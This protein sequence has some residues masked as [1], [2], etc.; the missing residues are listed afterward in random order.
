LQQSLRDSLKLL[1]KLENNENTHLINSKT[2]K[3]HSSKKS[4][5]LCGANIQDSSPNLDLKTLSHEKPLT[6]RLAS[7]EAKSATLGGRT[8]DDGLLTKALKNPEF[9]Y[10]MSHK[11][12]EKPTSSHKSYTIDV[13]L[14]LMPSVI[15][16]E[17]VSEEIK[18]YRFEAH[19]NKNLIRGKL[20]FINSLYQ[21]LQSTNDLNMN[22]TRSE[23]Q[24]YSPA[25]KV[26]QLF[27][28]RNQAMYSPLDHAH[29]AQQPTKNAANSPFEEFSGTGFHTEKKRTSSQ[30]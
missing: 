4:S 8:H 21:E 10:E 12:P 22:K 16:K 3:G 26:K 15:E 30:C 17:E 13:R 18:K 2:I 20:D 19:K 9:G 5:S 25:P 11:T 28:E 6:W 14:S 27:I 23:N 7:H 1:Q 24:K 29:A